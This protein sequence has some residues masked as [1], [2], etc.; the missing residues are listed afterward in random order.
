MKKGKFSTA[1]AYQLL[2]LQAPN[3]RKIICNNTASPSSLFICWL[4]LSDRLAT[5]DRM[6]KWGLPSLF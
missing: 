1:N 4:A 5:K 6:L 2:R 3:W